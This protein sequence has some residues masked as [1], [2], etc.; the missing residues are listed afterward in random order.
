MVKIG[1]V[2]IPVHFVGLLT[3]GNIP[4]G[5]LHLAYE[6][7]LGNGRGSILSRAGDAGDVNNKLSRLAGER[8]CAASQVLRIPSGWVVF[9]KDEKSRCRPERIFANG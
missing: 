5:G 3:E 6:V 8:F 7:G 2:F 9:T 4:S 1:G